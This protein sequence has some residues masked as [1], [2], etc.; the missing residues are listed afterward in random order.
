M[1]DTS[2]LTFSV[3]VQLYQTGQTLTEQFFPR[4]LLLRRTE[5]AAYPF[6]QF[7]LSIQL[8]SEGNGGTSRKLS[9]EFRPR[10]CNCKVFNPLRPN[11]VSVS[12]INTC[13][14]MKT[15]V[16][17]LVKVFAAPNTNKKVPDQSKRTIQKC[18]KQKETKTLTE[19]S[20][21]LQKRRLND[22]N[23]AWSNWG[24][25]NSSGASLT[26]FWLTS[27]R[28]T[29]HPERI[30]LNIHE[31]LN[32]SQR[33]IITSHDLNTITTL[34]H[35]DSRLPPNILC[36]V[37]LL[38]APPCLQTGLGFV[39]HCREHANWNVDCRFS[40]TCI[41]QWFSC[42][43]LLFKPDLVMFK[44]GTRK[45]QHLG[46]HLQCNTCCSKQPTYFE[47]LKCKTEKAVE[48]ESLYRNEYRSPTQWL[49]ELD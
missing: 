19:R 49:S 6:L 27:R 46:V 10:I 44:N 5:L 7:N 32:F 36:T 16:F 11:S 3:E 9:E 13:L 42:F 45:A 12:N 37:N 34:F 29:W 22:T 24:F 20:F 43:G 48:T 28:K 41:L 47:S 1:T 23:L 14:C 15:C 25:P 8:G 35:Y 4:H 40:R 30:S 31:P 26:P 2:W 17:S 21:R 33:L 39:T 18:K 38:W